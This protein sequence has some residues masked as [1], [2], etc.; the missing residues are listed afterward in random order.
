MI[1]NLSLL[2][3]EMSTV[4]VYVFS[5]V[6]TTDGLKE[7]VKSCGNCYHASVIYVYDKTKGRMVETKKNIVFSDEPTII[8]LQQKIAQAQQEPCPEELRA[9]RDVTVEVYNWATF[10][11]PKPE[12]NEECNLHVADIPNTFT[13]SRAT[14]FLLDQLSIIPGFDPRMVNIDLALQQREL[15]LVA[16]WGTIT[17]A[18]EVPEDIRYLCKLVLH[19]RYIQDERNDS[20]MTA[21]WHRSKI[22]GQKVFR[23]NRGRP[24]EHQGLPVIRMQK[25]RLQLRTNVPMM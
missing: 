1:L 14:K 16:G 2:G 19:N 24:E 6:K 13:L 8:N 5:C 15:G 22:E 9:Y 4:H 10:P 23:R 20:I 7:L 18:P 11:R 25:Q 21:T 3:K 12:M 17:F